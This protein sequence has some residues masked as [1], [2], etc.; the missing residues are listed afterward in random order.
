M[1]RRWGFGAAASGW[2]R[3]QA[4]GG[5]RRRRGQSHRGKL[6]SRGRRSGTSTWGMVASFQARET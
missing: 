2:G 5:A 3:A 4:P 1:V 6:F